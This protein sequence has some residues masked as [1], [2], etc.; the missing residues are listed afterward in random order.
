[1][2]RPGQG[3]DVDALPA[4]G[5]RVLGHDGDR[6]PVVGEGPSLLVEDPGVEGDVS[7]RQVQAAAW[8]RAHRPQRLAPGPHRPP[9]ADAGHG[10]EPCHVGAE[11]AAVLLVAEALDRGETEG[12]APPRWGQPTAE[13]GHEEQQDPDDGQRQED[14]LAGLGTSPESRQ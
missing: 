11:P 10:E 8:P 5:P 3:D 1:M 7:G 2:P 6:P 9:G 14:P 13:T 4:L 12:S